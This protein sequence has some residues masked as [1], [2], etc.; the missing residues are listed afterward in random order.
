MSNYKFLLSAFLFV[1]AGSHEAMPAS[2]SIDAEVN[3]MS[4][5]ERGEKAAC[6]DLERLRKDREI[7]AL[8]QTKCMADDSCASK[9]S[10]AEIWSACKTG[11]LIACQ[12][13]GRPGKMEK[14]ELGCIKGVGKDCYSFAESLFAT[15]RADVRVLNAYSVACDKGI[16]NGCIKA[17]RMTSDKVVGEQLARH[18]CDLDNQNAC[19]L[20]RRIREDIVYEET[21]KTA[22]AERDYGEQQLRLQR[23]QVEYDRFRDLQRAQGE[24]NEKFLSQMQKAGEK[25]Q[26]AFNVRREPAG[27]VDVTPMFSQPTLQMP[28]GSEVLN[29]GMPPIAKIG[30]H[31]GRCVNGKWEQV[32]N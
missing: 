18:G 10:K 23:E 11:D 20:M 30:Y 9:L 6:A 14:A 26:G 1:L 15:D 32:S 4:R 19:S 25:F 31:I 2:F 16:S 24:A 12:R 5:C 21:I 17:A 27:H 13:Y 3:L 7:G 28:S 22:K 29:C 8:S